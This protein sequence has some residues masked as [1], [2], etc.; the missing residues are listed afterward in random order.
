MG[1]GASALP[2]VHQRNDRSGVAQVSLRAMS[3]RS[4]GRQAPGSAKR[5]SGTNSGGDDSGTIVAGDESSP[6]G[7]AKRI[8]G[9]NSGGDDSGTIGAADE[10]SRATLHKAASLSDRR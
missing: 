4:R 8:S 3:F 6:P 2:R 10:S 7:S 9:T 1:L 5:I